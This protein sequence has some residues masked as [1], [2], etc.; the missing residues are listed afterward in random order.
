VS[1]P[2]SQTPNSKSFFE[3]PVYTREELEEKISKLS[4]EVEHISDLWLAARMPLDRILTLLY[5]KTSISDAS[6]QK[7]DELISELRSA[8]HDAIDELIIKE[9]GL[10]TDIDKY[11]EQYHVKFTYE[12]ERLLGV[13]MLKEDETV[14]PVVV[15]T[16]YKS[17]GYYEGEKSE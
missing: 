17:I 11:E 6:S 13:V 7:V 16:D 1:K 12:T 14:K 5:K 3:A 15:W 9:L 8:I 10:D 2:I 4:R